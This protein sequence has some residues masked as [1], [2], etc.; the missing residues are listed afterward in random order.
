M[1]S[2]LYIIFIIFLL[3]VLIF[4]VL[5]SVSIFTSKFIYNPISKKYFPDI[6]QTLELKDDSV[7]YMLPAGDSRLFF[8]ILKENKNVKIFGIEKNFFS[9]I[10]SNFYI[11]LNSRKYFLKKEERLNINNIEILKKDIFDIDLSN[12]THICLYIYPNIMDDMLTFL[13]DNLKKGTKVVSINFQFTQKRPTKEIELKKNKFQR[14][15]KIYV[16]EF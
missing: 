9:I 14:I 10:V 5:W 2:I 15:N 13:D 6:V 1:I 12:A 3:S 4:S 7:L 16:Y 8:S 11:F